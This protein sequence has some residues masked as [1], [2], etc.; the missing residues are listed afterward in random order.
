[1]KHT[2]IAFLLALLIAPAWSTDATAAS[3]VSIQVTSIVAST[4]AS[5]GQ[6]SGDAPVI[7]PKLSSYGEKLESLFAYRR[8][9]FAGSSRSEAGFGAACMF[10]LPERFSLEVEP[11]RFESEGPGRIEMLVTLFHDVQSRDEDLRDERGRATRREIVLRTRIRL[12]NGG[13]VLL[14]GPP[15]GDGVLLLALSARR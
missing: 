5:E 8:Y 13:V 12:E 15:V 11:E 7:D 9:S 10:Q 14:G 3:E 6:R 2:A 1:M 4:T